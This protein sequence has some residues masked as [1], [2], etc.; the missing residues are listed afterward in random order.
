MKRMLGLVIALPMLC[1]LPAAA[2]ANEVSF[3]RDEIASILRHGPWPPPR[4]RDSS[5]QVS[6][7]ARASAFGERLF[8]DARLSVNGNIACANCHMPAS[9]WADRRAMAAGL[10]QTQ[11]NTL[12]VINAGFNRWF[13]WSGA[14]DSLWAASLRPLLDRGEMGSAERHVAALVRRTPELACDYR[15]VFGRDPE[16]DDESVFV[17]VGKALAAY[18]ETLVSG[19]TPFDEFRDAL[20]R[21]D[22]AAAARYPLAAQ[23]G[24]RLF[25]GKGGCNT[26]HVGPHFTNGEFDKVGIPVRHADGTY[27]WGRYDGVKTVLASRFNLQS[28]YNDNPARAQAIST[29]HVALTVETYGAFKVPGLRNV[30]L[31]A[32]YMHDGSLAGLRDV[33]RHYSDIDEIKLHIAASHPHAE[34]GE[35]LPPRPAQVVPR[36]LNLTE[37]EMNDLVAFLETLTEPKPLMPNPAARRSA[38]CR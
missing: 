27:D 24:A 20:A 16:A 19:R 33:V 32:P 34:L 15:G 3:T 14:S 25:T 10:G 8:F 38:A 7:N 36:T 13:G 11:R 4:V 2:A 35:E 22:R 18:Q 37:K 29:R 21:N 6:G 1:G 30:S 23:R 5:N 9:G 31:T 17:N 28:R 12:S 26:C